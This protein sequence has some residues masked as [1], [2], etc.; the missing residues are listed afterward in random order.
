MAQFRFMGGNDR[1]FFGPPQLVVEP[2]DIVCADENPDPNWF[3]P[4]A[5]DPDEEE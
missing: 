5:A 3:E 1:V 4:V 2:G